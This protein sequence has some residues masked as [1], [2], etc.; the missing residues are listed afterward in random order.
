MLVL[1]GKQTEVLPTQQVEHRPLPNEP[2]MPWASL[3]KGPQHVVFGHD[4]GRKLQTWP[5]ATGLDTGCCYGGQ[6]TVLIIPPLH[7]APAAASLPDQEPSPGQ[8]TPAEQQ[9]LPQLGSQG[10]YEQVSMKVGDAGTDIAHGNSDVTAVKVIGSGKS[11]EV[12]TL[13]DMDASLVLVPAK[14]AYS[15]KKKIKPDA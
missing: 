4:A 14:K 8:L 10:V 1:S 11:A 5:C 9:A 3:W 6:L 2:Q 13:S 15:K 12:P 7:Q